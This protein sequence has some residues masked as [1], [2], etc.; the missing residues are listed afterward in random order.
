MSTMTIWQVAATSEIMIIANIAMVR[1]LG[2]R[3]H[4]RPGPTDGM[5][6][7]AFPQGPDPDSWRSPLE[8]RAPRDASSTNIAERHVSSQ[9]DHLDPATVEADTES[10][11]PRCLDRFQ[12]IVDAYAVTTAES[13]QHRDGDSR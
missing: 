5:P 10:M 7:T 1:V 2:R 3:T 8:R 4:R 12:R 9:L 11:S 6:A 13:G